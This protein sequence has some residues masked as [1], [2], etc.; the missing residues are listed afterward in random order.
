MGIA[1]WF[2]NLVGGAAAAV[3]VQEALPAFDYADPDINLPGNQ[4]AQNWRRLTQSSSDLSPLTH[5]RMLEMALYLS[6]RNPLAKGI[7]D[8]VTAFVVGEGFTVT[9]KDVTVQ[10]TIDRFW[11]DGQNDMPSRIEDLT[12]EL[13]IYGEQVVLAFENTASGRVVLVSAD[14]RSVTRVVPHPL[15]SDRPYAVCFGAAVVAAEQRWVKIITEDDDPA[16]KTFGR[17]VGQRD[18][19]RIKLGEESVPFYQP[20][21]SDGGAR[22]AGCFFVAV[23]KV[24]SAMRGRSDLLP[25]AD[26]IDLYDRLLFDEA[27]RMSFLRSFIIDVT[28]KGLSEDQVKSR[29]VEI[30]LAPPKPGSA[31]VHNE[32]E[33]WQM[34]SPDLNSD[35]SQNTADLI[36]SLVATGVGLP[37]T[38]LNG[39][40]DVNRA[41]ASE[42]SDPAIKRLTARQRVIT[43]TIEHMTRFV[44]DC[45]EE[46]GA[47]KTGGDARHSFIV[48]T[49]EMSSKDLE[50]A[51]RSL[52]TTTQALGMANAA[53]WIDQ[54]TAQDGVALMVTQ[55]GLDVDVA[56]LRERLEAAKAEGADDDL[57]EIPPYF[58]VGKEFGSDSLTKA[59]RTGGPG[60]APDD[61][62]PQ[63]RLMD[64]VQITDIISKISKSLV[65]LGMA[66]VID[67]QF[68]QEVVAALFAQLGIQ[69][70]PVAMQARLEAE[71]QAA[72]EE[73]AA[74]AAPDEG[75]DE[76]EDDLPD[77]VDEMIDLDA[78]ALEEARSLGHYS[79]RESG[80][81]WTYDEALTVGLQLLAEAFDASLHPRGPGG[82]FAAKAKPAEQDGGDEGGGS[83]N[84]DVE[85]RALELAREMIAKQQAKKPRK[86]KDP[87]APKKAPAKPTMAQADMKAAIASMP[88]GA[89]VTLTLANGLEISGTVEVR[90]G[91]V[92][93]VKTADGKY[94]A[95][96]P[97]LK[98]I[99]SMKSGDTEITPAPKKPRAKKTETGEDGEAPPKKPRAPRTAEQKAESAR[100]AAATRAA[101]KAAE[102]E[103][104]A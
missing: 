70:D 61:A 54:Q 80:H 51:A 43:R 104:A 75:E 63:A 96:H 92:A 69:V 42:M 17:L 58:G 77:S 46:A 86:P 57:G 40:M 73:E 33:E 72:E 97:G 56:E 24:R 78:M 89:E 47:L 83:A 81:A 101:R 93:M 18:G 59:L 26:F 103:T 65:E 68:A 50:R 36:L 49:P 34:I 87:N 6:D 4:N 66:R 62:D 39:I 55:L 52:L 12:R 19:E 10:E 5:E 102:K 95:L 53:G 14:P 71:K 9:S 8:V 45:A 32:S 35:D 23:N 37:K 20:P 48:S 91:D 100:K 64:P 99:A 76:E 41:T 21:D 88:V 27:E 31:I 67:G 74:A 15:A 13:T 82:K 38:F 44:L 16:S 90:S 1:D 2:A 11:E 30:G 94:A 22:L 60:A 84:P 25:V 98:G 28:C 7:V 85:A 29:A 3:P 79:L